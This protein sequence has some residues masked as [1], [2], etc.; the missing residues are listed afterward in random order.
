MYDCVTIYALVLIIMRNVSVD[1]TEVKIHQN[2]RRDRTNPIA[3]SSS[4]TEAPTG[5]VR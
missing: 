5:G 2:V 4:F 3:A 1:R